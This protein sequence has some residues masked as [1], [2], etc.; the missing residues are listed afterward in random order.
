MADL[1]FFLRTALKK[2]K[3]GRVSVSLSVL[4]FYLFSNPLSSLA[5]LDCLKFG[6]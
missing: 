1:L 4:T 2:I 6:E 5:G 3:G